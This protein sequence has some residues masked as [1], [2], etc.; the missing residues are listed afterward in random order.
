MAAILV[1]CGDTLKGKQIDFTSSSRVSVLYSGSSMTSRFL[2]DTPPRVCGRS[3]QRQSRRWNVSTCG[4]YIYRDTV[5]NMW[6][7]SDKVVRAGG[8]PAYVSISE[9]LANPHRDASL[10][11][12]RA[13]TAHK[14]RPRWSTWC[15]CILFSDR[16]SPWVLMIKSL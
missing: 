7:R 8:Y 6:V 12:L 13:F 4:A 2:P 5:L 15:A 10:Q 14:Q 3:S 11:R 9:M 1:W 16:I